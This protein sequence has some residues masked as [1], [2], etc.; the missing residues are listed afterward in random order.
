MHLNTLASD[1]DLLTIFRQLG[2]Y[3]ESVAC[4][5]GFADDWDNIL[6]FDR[7]EQ[8]ELYDVSKIASLH[9]FVERHQ[10]HLVVG[11][12]EYE[13]GL[14]L[15]ELD[16]KF[17]S[18]RP[19]VRLSAYKSYLCEEEGQLYGYNFHQDDLD[20][21]I[22]SKQTELTAPK[23]S[24]GKEIVIDNYLA[25][26]NNIQDYIRAGDIYQ[27]NYTHKLTGQT[28]TSG[29]D[30][31]AYYM[32]HKPVSHAAYLAGDDYEII[33][34]SPEGFIRVDGQKIS[35]QPIKGTRPRGKTKEQDLTL[36]EEL[37]TSKKEQAELFMIVDLL[38]ND[39][40]KVC[41]TGS[42][43]VIDPKI[44]TAMPNV[45]HTH[46]TIQGQ[47]KDSMGVIDALL[48]M[49]PGGS[50]TGCPKHRAMEIIDELESQPRGI[51]TGSVGYILPTGSASF[52]IAIRTMVKSGDSFSLGVGGGITIKSEGE[53]E[54]DETLA[55]AAFFRDSNT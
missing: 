13:L 55:K 1:H 11:S 37:I 2:E 5:R 44:V 32:T 4:I 24:W 43:R 38:R 39:L 21:L 29:K 8:F 49:F 12:L 42:V 50:I 47:L 51:Y 10:E 31:F 25:G 19:L 48:S 15:H 53:D 18:N 6:A 27:I 34:L 16:S 54:Y 35:A 40:G 28:D 7:I 22:L 46:A 45:W 52:N 41:E 9:E 14:M 23:L 20:K 36:R 26:F 30:I 33:S 17:Q 3:D